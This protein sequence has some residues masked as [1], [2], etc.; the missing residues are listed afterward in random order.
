MASVRQKRH[1][2][3]F[4]VIVSVGHL[5]ASLGLNEISVAGNGFVS[6]FRHGKLIYQHFKL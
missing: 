4:I 1:I 5:G 6:C 2:V 3:I